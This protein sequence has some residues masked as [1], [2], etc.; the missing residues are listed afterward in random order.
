VDTVEEA[1]GEKVQMPSSL[2]AAMKAE[3]NA[4]LIPADFAA[5]K[6]HLLR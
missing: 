6:S 3:K 1:T 2:L 5:L 4:T